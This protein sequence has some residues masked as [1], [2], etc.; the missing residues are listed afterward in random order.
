MQGVSLELVSLFL[1]DFMGGTDL[2]EGLLWLHANNLT[3]WVSR[4][5][6]VGKHV[7][8]NQPYLDFADVGANAAVHSVEGDGVELALIQVDH[9]QLVGLVRGSQRS[10]QGKL[11]L[12]P[13]PLSWGAGVGTRVDWTGVI[14]LERIAIRE[15]LEAHKEV[16]LEKTLSGILSPSDQ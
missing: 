9:W 11:E 1:A 12:V 6:K 16:C 2:W 14:F 10:S 5:S 15:R 13:E 8:R 4:D 7:P 3:T